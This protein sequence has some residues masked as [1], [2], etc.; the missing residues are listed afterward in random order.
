MANIS[1]QE[2]HAHFGLSKGRI[3]DMLKDQVIFLKKTKLKRQLHI[4][5][6]YKQT[7]AFTLSKTNKQTILGGF[8]KAVGDSC[9]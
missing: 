3:K 5:K 6:L 7:D 9:C 4:K 8:H 2:G 1:T